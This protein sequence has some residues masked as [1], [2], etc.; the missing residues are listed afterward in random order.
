[1]S[2]QAAF[3]S[4]YK[5]KLAICAIFQ[6]EAPYLKE[7]IEFHK[8][9]GVQHFYLYNNLSTDN[10]FSVLKPYI[11]K[12]EVELINWNYCSANICEWNEIQ[13]GSYNDALSRTRNVVE[14]VA[15]VDIDEFI[16]PVKEKNLIK[17]LDK[18]K[19]FAGVCV[20]WQVYGT[21]W[22][23]KIANNK[24]L[25]EELTFRASNECDSHC[26]VKSIVRPH[27]VSHCNNPHWFYYLDGFCQVDASKI[28]FCGPRTAFPKTRTIRINHYQFRDEYWF[29][30]FKIPRYIK[31]FNNQEQYTDEWIQHIYDYFNVIEDR[32]IFRYVPSLRKCLQ[33]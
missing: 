15:F 33:K 18:Y 28:P 30:N 31:Y 22:I 32:A 3:L 26:L 20:N 24:L 2:V 1:M 16:V 13:C 6:D 25:I 21:S 10:Y 29:I 14:W 8:L 17:F 4:A 11:E 19:H 23:K 9:V 27:Y 7:W 5:Y 12:G